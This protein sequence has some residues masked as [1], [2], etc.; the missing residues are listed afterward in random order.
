MF[1][2]LT[3][4]QQ[5]LYSDSA[6][7]ERALNDNGHDKRSWFY[8]LRPQYLLLNLERLCREEKGS[9]E[10]KSQ[11]RYQESEHSLLFHFMKLTFNLYLHFFRICLYLPLS[12]DINQNQTK[13]GK[14][15][16]FKGVLKASP[17]DRNARS[18]QNSH[19]VLHNSLLRFSFIRL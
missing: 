19:L 4:I 16:N 8:A 14:S 9:C 17:N 1:F 2:F 18:Q 11:S 15:Y 12:S 6:V 7:V 10:A 13:Y 5:L 3:E